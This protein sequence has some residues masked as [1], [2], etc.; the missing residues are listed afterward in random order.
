MDEKK[1]KIITISIIVVCLVLAVSIT[2]LTRTTD[3]TISSIK[4]GETILVKCANPD[5]QAEYQ[6][7]KRDYFEFMQQNASPLTPGMPPMVCRQCDEDSIYQA[8]E[9]KMCKI[10]FFENEGTDDF[11]DRCPE[12]DY[13]RSEELRN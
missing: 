3:N 1:K 12:C 10:V 13:S 7:G 9:C 4:K 2:Y 6:M 11:K 8:I 5:C